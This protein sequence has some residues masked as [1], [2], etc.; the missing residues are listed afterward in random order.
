MKMKQI[1]P[2]GDAHPK[3]VYVDPSQFKAR[4]VSDGS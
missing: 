1:G 4:K 3:F 2:R